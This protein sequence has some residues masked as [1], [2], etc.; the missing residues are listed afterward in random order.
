MVVELT[1]C[2]E[3]V[4]RYIAAPVPAVDV[5]EEVLRKRIERGE[6]APGTGVADAHLAREL[7]VSRTPCAR[8][9]RRCTTSP[10]GR[11]RT[12]CSRW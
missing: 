12:A 9:G 4:Y 5:V 3:A 10:P 7:E 6:L 8:Q 1:T 2:L 11:S